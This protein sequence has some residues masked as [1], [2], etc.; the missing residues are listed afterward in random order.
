M[1]GQAKVSHG[2][3]LS[4]YCFRSYFS[5]LAGPWTPHH[6]WWAPLTSSQGKLLH[7]TEISFIKTKP[8]NVLFP[9]VIM[10][11]EGNTNFKEIICDIGVL[12][13]IG[14]GV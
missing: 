13:M 11:D 10:T 12:L 3:T 6:S 14:W 1:V 9:T 2:Y 7:F 4:T 5:A 8:F